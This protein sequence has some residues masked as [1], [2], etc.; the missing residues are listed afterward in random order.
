MQNG[1]IANRRLRIVVEMVISFRLTKEL[2]NIGVW[3]SVDRGLSS[4]PSGNVDVFMQL[5]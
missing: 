3:W 2:S 1:S 5:Q 4:F